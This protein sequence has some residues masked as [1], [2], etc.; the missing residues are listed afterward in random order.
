MNR[1]VIIVNGLP[2]AGKDSTIDFMRGHLRE[3]R[4]QAGSF[5]SID[6]VRAMLT[7]L[8]IDLSAKT[9]ADRKLMAE[10]GDSLQEHGQWRTNWSVMNALD[11]FGDNESGVFFIHMREPALIAMVR[12]RLESLEIKVLTVLVLSNRAEMI[13]NN[14]ADAGVLNGR[15]NE[16][17]TND[18][19]LE[20]LESATFKLLIKQGII[21]A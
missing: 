11:F 13:T 20:D 21:S 7:G 5:S 19:T 12:K 16:R 18:G 15:Y 17:I 6:P 14:R 2:R 1:T 4:I 10:V 8:G 9:P 3:A